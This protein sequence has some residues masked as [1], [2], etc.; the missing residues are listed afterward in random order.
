MGS[1][2]SSEDEDRCGAVMVNE[3]LSQK[4]SEDKDRCGQVLDGVSGERP[5]DVLVDRACGTG[6]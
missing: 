1:Q 5:I 3:L 6:D 4:S 2:K